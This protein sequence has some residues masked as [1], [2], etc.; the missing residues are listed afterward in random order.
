MLGPEV[1]PAL[2]RCGIIN[3][4]INLDTVLT[5]TQFEFETARAGKAS[6]AHHHTF[7]ATTAAFE[8]LH[9]MRAKEQRS[10]TFRRSAV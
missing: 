5:A 4:Y 2:H 1:D 9:I 6:A 3:G 8:E 7:E 10:E